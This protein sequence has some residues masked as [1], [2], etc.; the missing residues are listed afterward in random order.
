MGSKSSSRYN[1]TDSRRQKHPEIQGHPK[2]I[3][4]SL[5]SKM[6]TGEVVVFQR[7]NVTWVLP[8]LGAALTDHGPAQSRNSQNIE[9]RFPGCEC[10]LE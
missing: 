8:A 10:V 2:E 3:M 6:R 1:S 4:M 7:G 5:I 9:T